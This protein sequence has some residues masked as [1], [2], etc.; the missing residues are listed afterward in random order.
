MVGG[1]TRSGSA[2]SAGARALIRLLPD[3]RLDRGFGTGGRAELP[4]VDTGESAI[5][6]LLRQSDARIVAGGYA[7][8]VR[9]SRFAL[10]RFR[11]R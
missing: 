2:G 7:G 5:N 1:D 10:M 6:A 8:S 11:S 4:R 3:G 9:E